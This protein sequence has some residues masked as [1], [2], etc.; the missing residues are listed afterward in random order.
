MTTTT[1]DPAAYKRTT[2]AQWEAAAEA[3]DRWGPAIE[4]WL[5]QATEVM[6]D[7]A[8]ITT[9]SRV[10]DVAA[11]AGGQTL[12]AAERVG[13]VWTRACHRHLADD[14]GVCRAGSGTSRAPG[15]LGT[16]CREGVRR[17]G[18]MDSSS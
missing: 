14:S 5:G 17:F 3:W 4:D 15:A 11:G 16:K 10:L 6:L 7:G 13:P 12:A 8:A 9:G 18:S 2:L 1:F